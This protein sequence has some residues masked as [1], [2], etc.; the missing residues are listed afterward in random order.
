MAT[1]EELI[2]AQMSVEEIRAHIGADSLG[3][4]SLDGLVRATD[5]QRDS[6]CLA[7][8]NGDYPIPV[9]SSLDKFGLERSNVIEL[10]LVGAAD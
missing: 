7:C 8:F 9:E 5:M 4:L 6:F 1:R 10:A 2:G 3:F